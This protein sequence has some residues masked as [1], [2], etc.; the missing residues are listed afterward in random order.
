VRGVVTKPRAQEEAENLLLG[1]KQAASGQSGYRAKVTTQR[2][3]PRG[4]AKG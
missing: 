2:D 1:L 4:Q 3:L